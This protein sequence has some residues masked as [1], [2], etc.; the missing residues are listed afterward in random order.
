MLDEWTS[1]PVVRPL[2]PNEIQIWRL[3]L[4]D[5]Q[6][7][8]E[9]CR[10][11]L[12]RDERNQADRKL[13]GRVRNEFIYGRACLRILLSLNLGT[14]ASSVLI[15]SSQYGKPYLCEDPAL[16]FNVSHS[17]GMVLIALSKQG[18]VGIDLECRN[19]RTQVMKL[20]P[21][22]LSPT[23]IDRLISLNTDAGS[24]YFHQVWTR[25]EAIVKADGRGLSLPL[26]SFDLPDE[27]SYNMP[28]RVEDKLYYLNDIVA[29]EGYMSAIAMESSN[30]HIGMY[31]FPLPALASSE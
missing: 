11:I 16:N 26:T 21:R 15:A 2:D 13:P 12:S 8:F 6:G 22:V 23:E 20:A 14:A 25:R 17:H 19:E 10:R 9:G 29:G 7:A 27:P 1:A 3:P 18:G 4:E 24:R 31:D 28:V 5:A 30:C